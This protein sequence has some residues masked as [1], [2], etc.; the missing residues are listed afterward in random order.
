MKKVIYI[1]SLLLVLSIAFNVRLFVIFVES[2]DDFYTSMSDSL[3]IEDKA[4]YLIENNNV[5]IAKE[6]LTK[7]VSEKSLLIG[8]CTQSK[9]VSEETIKKIN[10]R[11]T[12]K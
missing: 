8:I 2:H 5:N 9:C 10:T 1:L 7:A 12:G 6:V 4:L 11:F 3:K